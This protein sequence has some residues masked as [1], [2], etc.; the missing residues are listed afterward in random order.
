MVNKPAR[1]FW[2]CVIG[3]AAPFLATDIASAAGLGSIYSLYASVAA[4]GLIVGAW[5]A[6][7]LRPRFKDGTW[8]VGAST[9]GW[10][11]A[12]GTVAVASWMTQQR[13]VRGVWGLVAY[14][15]V[16]A[17]GGLILG[18]ATGMTLVWMVRREQS[19]TQP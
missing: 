12:G 2:S 15:V 3:L 14:L 16:V 9:L 1:W 8:W 4:G 19:S 18:L 5:Q 10:S 6:R 13:Q 17:I 7:L 11:V